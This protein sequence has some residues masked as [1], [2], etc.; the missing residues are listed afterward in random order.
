MSGESGIEWLV[1]RE[2]DANAKEFQILTSLLRHNH[3]STV[4]DLEED[5]EAFEI[6]RYAIGTFCGDITYLELDKRY[7]FS[8]SQV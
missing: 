2:P 8:K 4:V 7:D 5:D 3:Y 1:F 6:E